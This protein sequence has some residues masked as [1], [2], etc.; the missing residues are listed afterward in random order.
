MNVLTELTHL[1]VARPSAG[2][3]AETVAAWY[4]A[5]SRLHAHLAELGGPDCE[6]ERA[7]AK[8][9]QQRAADLLSPIG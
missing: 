3:P 1:S 2:A 5:K 7:L 6:H 9:A 8:R 4:A